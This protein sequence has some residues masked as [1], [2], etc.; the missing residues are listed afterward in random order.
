MSSDRLTAPSPA[1][2]S[3]STQ[4]SSSKELQLQDLAFNITG[5]A[6]SVGD[7]HQGTEIYQEINAKAI[8]SCNIPFWVTKIREHEARNGAALEPSSFRPSLNLSKE[9]AK[10][11]DPLPEGSARFLIVGYAKHGLNSEKHRKSYP[12]IPYSKACTQRPQDS[13]ILSGTNGTTYVVAEMVHKKPVPYAEPLLYALL[14]P[15]N[16]LCTPYRISKEDVFFRHEYRK[17]AVPSLQNRRSGWIRQVANHVVFGGIEQ[18]FS[19]HDQSGVGRVN[20]TTPIITERNGDLE[21]GTRE[22]TVET[23][24]VLDRP[25]GAVNS[26]LLED[27]AF[28]ER[29]HKIMFR[30]EMEKLMVRVE[31]DLKYRPLSTNE[32]LLAFAHNAMENFEEH[33][34]AMVVK[35]IKKMWPRTEYVTT[36]HVMRLKQL[37]E[38]QKAEIQYF[39]LRPILSEGIYRLEQTTTI[40]DEALWVEDLLHNVTRLVGFPDDEASQPAPAAS[41]MLNDLKRKLGQITQ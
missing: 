28:L 34:A 38:T 11:T 41:P 35:E 4:N 26:G 5:W 18:D 22:G 21:S 2:A 7:F 29:P 14:Y 16:G 39:H 33:H 1:L 25:N 15:S 12:K 8:L 40:E 24:N 3:R 32:G 23:R 36:N 19:R 37:L 9:E 13:D 17:V 10:M 27:I 30:K 31:A 6:L 20:E